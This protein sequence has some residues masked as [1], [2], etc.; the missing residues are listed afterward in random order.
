MKKKIRSTNGIGLNQSKNKDNFDTQVIDFLPTEVK[1]VTFFPRNCIMYVSVI[2]VSHMKQC[3]SL[4]SSG[5]T[6]DLY[7]DVPGLTEHTWGGGGGGGRGKRPELKPY[8]VKGLSK[9]SSVLSTH[10]MGLGNN[11]VHYIAFNL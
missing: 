5:L 2:T 4:K 3:D 9:T 7:M 8:Y 10:F 6:R 11:L 1:D